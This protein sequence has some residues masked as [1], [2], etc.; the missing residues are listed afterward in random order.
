MLAPCVA[1]RGRR[2]T[3]GVEY[4][5]PFREESCRNSCIYSSPLHSCSRDTVKPASVHPRWCGVN[6][7][8]LYQARITSTER[9]RSAILVFG[10]NFEETPKTLGGPR[11]RATWDLTSW[12]QAWSSRGISFHV[13]DFFLVQRLLLLLRRASVA[14]WC[15]AG[16]PTLLCTL[17][18]T[19]VEKNVGQ[20]V[21]V[22]VHTRQMST[23]QL[24]LAQLSVID[25]C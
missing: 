2:N 15:R 24:M 10:G 8:D 21:L 25:T 4:N 13:T 7:A 9:P 18:L 16:F 3:S 14:I 19:V 5:V 11:R 1:E 22:E 20:A 23:Q 17:C 12:E 6:P